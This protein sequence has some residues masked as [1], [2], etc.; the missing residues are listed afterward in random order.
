MSKLTRT[1][2]AQ[3][4]S[5]KKPSTLQAKQLCDLSTTENMKLF[6]ILA[7]AASAI[8]LLVQGAPQITSEELGKAVAELRELLNSEAAKSAWYGGPYKAQSANRPRGHVSLNNYDNAY[9]PILLF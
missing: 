6:F 4:L 1:S 7:V 8:V 3:D 9:A 5:K 2:T